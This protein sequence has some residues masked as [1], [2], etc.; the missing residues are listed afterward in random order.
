MADE[1]KS[2]TV[3]FHI[4]FETHDHTESGSMGVDT[5]D[6]LNSGKPVNNE[7][8]A[9]QY[10]EDYYE[11]NGEDKL[12]DIPQWIWDDENGVG[13]ASFDID[14]VILDVDEEEENERKKNIL[15]EK[16]LGKGWDE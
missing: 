16:I 5:S 2:W 8:D 12:V 11:G 6:V 13:D 7:E 4:V 9:Q 1:I 10:V 3:K 14:E 15:R